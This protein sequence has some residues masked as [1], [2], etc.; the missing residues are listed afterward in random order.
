MRGRRWAGLGI[1]AATLCTPARATWGIVIINHATREVGVACA[2]CIEDIDL[3]PRLPV[4]RP[5]LGVG[6]VQAWWD[7]GVSR[8]SVMWDGFGQGKTPQEILD[9]LRQLPQHF[10]YQFGIASFAGPPVTFTGTTAQ[11]GICNVAGSDGVWSYAI[12][13]NV[14]T[15]EPVCW[16]AEQAICSTDGDMAAKLMAAMEAA[17]SMGGDG[18]CSCG[19][20]ADGCGSPPPSF[21]KSAHTAFLIVARYGD[22]EGGCAAGSGCA[23]GAYYLSRDVV[24]SANDPDPVVVLGQKVALWRIKQQG[25]PDQILSR[26]MLDR[27]QLVADGASRARVTVELRDIDDVPLSHGGAQLTVV[28]RSPGQATA[29][30]GPVTDHGDGSY[31]FDLRATDQAGRGQWEIVVDFGGAKTRTLWPPL[32]IETVALQDLFA[33]FYDYPAGTGLSVPFE[34]NRGSGEAG[35]AYQLLGTLSGTVP[36]V[37]LALV[38]LPLNRDSFFEQTWFHPGAADFPGSIGVLD[39]AGHAEARLSL[40]P[41]TSMALVGERFHFCA[42]LG[43]PADGITTVVTLPIIP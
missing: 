41:A 4:V 30:A 21:Q 36:G 23:D 14:I 17:R 26:V 8:R 32:A 10:R 12:Q 7:S 24:G 25:R 27:Q 43:S 20:P 13:G 34:L 22:Q 1:L 33:G 19:Y 16:M 39:G 28:Q 40:P 29:L 38:H 42:L 5:G 6:N 18:R 3:V 2:T 37:D 31:S 15:G 35:R 9:E 11:P